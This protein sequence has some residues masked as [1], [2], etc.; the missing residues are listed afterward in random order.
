MLSNLL[1]SLISAESGWNGNLALAVP[2]PLPVWRRVYFAQHDEAAGSARLAVCRA[3]SGG[4]WTTNDALEYLYKCMCINKK[5]M[6]RG[7]TARLIPD[8]INQ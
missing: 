7:L 1:G 6:R 2:M 5:L 8:R 4:R 3:G